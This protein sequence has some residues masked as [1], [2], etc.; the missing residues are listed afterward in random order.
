MRGFYVELSDGSSFSEDSVKQALS[1]YVDMYGWRELPPWLILKEYLKL[2]SLKITQLLLKIDHQTVFIPKNSKV[3]FYSKKV[4]A[5]FG[6]SAD[7][8]QYYGVGAS[9]HSDDEVEITWYNGNDSQ[10]EK[11]KVDKDGQA[12]F[13][14]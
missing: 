11:R 7:Q 2:K 9:Y 12:F 6:G 14:N 3:Y 10:V 5:F 8:R 13:I 1:G 4:E